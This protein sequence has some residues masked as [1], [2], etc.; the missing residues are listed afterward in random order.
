MTSGAACPTVRYPF[1]HPT[2]LRQTFS[3]SS[4]PCHALTPIS[5]YDDTDVAMDEACATAF[6]AA[7]EEFKA[8]GGK[9]DGIV[10]WIADADEAKKVRHPVLPVP[11]ASDCRFARF[12]L[13]EDTVPLGLRC[14]VLPRWL[15][16]AL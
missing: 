2:S 11:I 6:H 4:S 13:L 5:L 12:E 15:D 7:Y 9:V 16:V 8:D 14:C 1:Q 3:V 10:E